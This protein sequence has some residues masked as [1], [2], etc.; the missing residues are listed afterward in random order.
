MKLLERHFEM[1]LAAPDGIKKLRELILTLAMQGKLV[2]QD[3]SDQPASELLKQIE[4]EKKKLIKEGKI[5]K[6]EP[7]PPIKPEE[8]P[9]AVPDGWAWVRLGDISKLITKGS[10]PKWQGVNYTSADQGILFI[11]SENVDN[12]C[13]KFQ[14][15]KFVEIK[16]NEIEPR[17]ILQKF[18]ILM[19]IVGASIGRVAY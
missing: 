15:R 19:N 12:Y 14:N 3:P 11:T 17:S 8:V 6:Q 7:L 2:P 4:A 1:A 10:S 16:F 9:Y 13:L 18:D 5:K